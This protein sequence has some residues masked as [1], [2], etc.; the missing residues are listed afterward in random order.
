MVET[1][2][3]V[4]LDM[5][6]TRRPVKSKISNYMKKYTEITEPKSQTLCDKITKDEATKITKRRR[7]EPGITFGH[8]VYTQVNCTVELG[9]ITWFYASFTVKMSS[10]IKTLSNKGKECIFVDDFRFSNCYIRKNGTKNS[11]CPQDSSSCAL[12][13]TAT[14]RCTIYRRVRVSETFTTECIGFMLL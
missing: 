7:C 10:I 5:H 12:L 9:V 14:L 8:Y 3:P 13:A 11:S 6:E 2:S 1:M 4:R